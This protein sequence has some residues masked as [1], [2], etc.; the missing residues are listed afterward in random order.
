[1]FL[2]RSDPPVLG[3]P[4]LRGM[5][6]SL[7]SP[8]LNIE[9]LPVG[10]ARAL[11]VLHDEEPTGMTLTVAIRC[12]EGGRIALFSYRGELKKA[13]SPTV[14]MDGALSFAEGMGFLFDEDLIEFGGPGGR[15]RALRHWRDLLGEPAAAVAPAVTPE[16][17]PAP[18]P[19]PAPAPVEPAELELAAEFCLDEVIDPGDD[20]VPSPLAASEPGGATPA[21]PAPAQ[22]PLPLTKFRS[23][24]APAPATAPGSSELGRVP[25]VKMR[26]GGDDRP[27]AS[28]LIRLLGSF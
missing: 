20:S 3:E 19:I 1:M 7:N 16:I 4:S 24:P 2:S 23:R 22:H 9:D 8:V 17:A 18:V 14:V 26:K 21:E 28:I 5:C 15:Q 25:I 6:V 12:L 11:I 27:E 13:G 10:P